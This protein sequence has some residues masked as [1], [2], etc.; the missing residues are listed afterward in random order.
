MSRARISAFVLILAWAASA[1]GATLFD[2]ALKFRVL[3]T[4]HF[5]I[6]FHQGEEGLAGRLAAIAEETWR[7]LL[8]A[9]RR[10]PPRLTP[11]G[12]TPAAAR[13]RTA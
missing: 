4:E 8:A 10:A 3:P 12:D 1:S 6:Y 2:P 5:L 11:R 7:A 9:Q 13:S